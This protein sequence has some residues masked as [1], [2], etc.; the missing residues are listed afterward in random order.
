[1]TVKL[2]ELLEPVII[3]KGKNN[4]K[5]PRPIVAKFVNWRFAGEIRNKIINLNKTKM[6]ENIFCNQMFSKELLL[7]RKNMHLAQ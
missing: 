5:G 7:R 3:I 6:L 2:A 1:M 4:R